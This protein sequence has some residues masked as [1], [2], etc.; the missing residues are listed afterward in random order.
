MKDR[1]GLNLSGG[2]GG[3]KTGRSGGKGNEIR[4]CCM[5]KNPF[6]IKE[7]EP[8]IAHAGVVT[9]RER[10][11]G[12][13]PLY[14]EFEASLGYIRSYALSLKVFLIIKRLLDTWVGRQ[15]MPIKWIKDS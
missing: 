14:N 4:I 1:K 11:E 10:T 7:K 13:L 5:T 8:I 6:S 9:G 15:R 2:G 3:K 12:H